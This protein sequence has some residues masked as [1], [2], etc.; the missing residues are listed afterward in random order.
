MMSSY[1][2]QLSSRRNVMMWGYMHACIHWP[3]PATAV[4]SIVL[5]GHPTLRPYGFRFQSAYGGKFGNASCL[6]FFHIRFGLVSSAL[7]SPS[8]R[9]CSRDHRQGP[10]EF[11]AVVVF[12]TGGGGNGFV[13]VPAS[14][15]VSSINT[16]LMG[17]MQI[18]CCDICKSSGTACLGRQAIVERLGNGHHTGSDNGNGR[19][20]L[21]FP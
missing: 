5:D 7:L 4:H 14:S 12:R 17:A 8:R 1:L 11:F 18:Q 9:S 3:S 13:N 20:R 6:S 15:H 16:T 19:V 21:L 10:E 2:S